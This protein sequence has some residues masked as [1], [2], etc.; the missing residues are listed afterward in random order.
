MLDIDLVDR[1]GGGVSHVA[2]DGEDDTGAE[3]ATGSKLLPDMQHMAM[4]K[5]A[6]NACGNH[7]LSIPFLQLPC[8]AVADGN[9]DS[10]PHAVVIEP[11]H[12]GNWYHSNVM[13]TVRIGDGNDDYTGYHFIAI[14]WQL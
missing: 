4:N 14:L 11:A 8:G 1:A 7:R 2:K 6:I 3:N 5:T 10:V 9:Q 13:A 12:C